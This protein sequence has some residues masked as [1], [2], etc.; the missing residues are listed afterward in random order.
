MDTSISEKFRTNYG[1]L[2]TKESYPQNEWWG[3]VC[4][5]ELA[6]SCGQCSTKRRSQKPKVEAK[7]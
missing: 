7:F 6:A 2:K 1:F 3:I 4:S 5:G